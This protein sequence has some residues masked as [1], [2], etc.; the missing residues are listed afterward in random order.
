MCSCTSKDSSV[1]L[2]VYMAWFSLLC[3]ACPHIWVSFGDSSILNMLPRIMWGH[4]DGLGASVLLQSLVR[5]RLSI[6]VCWTGGWFRASG[7]GVHAADE[8]CRK[9]DGQKNT[10]DSYRHCCMVG[11]C[12]LLFIFWRPRNLVNDT[13]SYDVTTHKT[14][15]AINW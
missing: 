9:L 7:L 3:Q 13:G 2:T 1:P 8:D 6:S 5:S 11:I 12:S 15:W 4:L 10:V 14:N